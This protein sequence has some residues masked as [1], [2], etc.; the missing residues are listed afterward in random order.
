MHHADMFPQNS[1]V[2]WKSSRAVIQ[3]NT[4]NAICLKRL[5]VANWI[6]SNYVRPASRK[7]NILEST[8]STVIKSPNSKQDDFM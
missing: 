4:V 2:I 1:S 3:R 5:E 7:C 8:I 6:I